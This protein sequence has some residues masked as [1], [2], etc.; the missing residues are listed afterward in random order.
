MMTREPFAT[1]E[2][3]HIYNR[4]TNKMEIFKDPWD[5]LRFQ[6]LIYLCN[7]KNGPKYSDIEISPGRTWTV[8]NDETLVDIGAYCLMPNHFH[9]LI[10]VK[11]GSDASVFLLK[12][13]TSYSTYFN[14]K[15]NRSGS[16]FQGKTKSEHANSDEYLKY[17]FSYIHLNPVKLINPKWKENGITDLEKTLEFLKSYQYS[18]FL[19]YYGINRVENKTIDRNAFPEYFINPEE[20]L[21]EL[22]EWLNYDNK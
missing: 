19:D 2:I 12:I 4:G 10:K 8:E 14:K 16:L 22:I 13:L 18:S 15:N 17:L 3:Y 5:Y 20:H 1:G 7:I 9:I 6:K 11:E 21:K